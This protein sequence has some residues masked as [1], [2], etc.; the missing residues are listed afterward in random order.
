MQGT[1][2]LKEHR[3]LI[4]AFIVIALYLAP[5]YIL[6]KNTPTL[7]HDNLDSTAVWFTILAD[8]GQLFGSMDA[9]ILQVIMH[10]PVIHLDQT[11]VLF[12][13]L[14]VFLS[15]IQHIPSTSPAALGCIY[16]DVLSPL[17][18]HPTE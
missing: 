11:S 17:P 3:Y 7:V 2:F 16:W 14:S 15:H 1:V 5:F 4:A 10:S 8:S 13:A 9:T 18:M 6:E 12:N